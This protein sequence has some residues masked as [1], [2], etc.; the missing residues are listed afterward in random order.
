MPQC[1]NKH[2]IKNDD[3]FSGKFSTEILSHC[4]GVGRQS[5]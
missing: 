5:E 1:V 4:I 2:W 3:I